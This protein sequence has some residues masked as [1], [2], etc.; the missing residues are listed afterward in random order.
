MVWNLHHSLQAEGLSQTFQLEH[1]FVQ[2]H[3]SYNKNLEGVLKYAE[4][5]GFGSVVYDLLGK[6]K[7]HC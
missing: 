4:A 2:N 1:H 6:Q 5:R 3:V 7:L